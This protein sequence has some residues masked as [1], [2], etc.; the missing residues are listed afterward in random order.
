M[1]HELESDLDSLINQKHELVFEMYQEQ[2]PDFKKIENSL[3]EIWSLL[4]NPKEN[5][6]ESF[7]TANALFVLYLEDFREF[8][9]AEVWLDKLRLVEEKIHYS[10]GE[11]LFCEGRLYFELEEYDKAFKTFKTTVKEGK[12]LRYFEDEDPKYLDFYTH[13][14]KYQ[15]K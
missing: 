15:S 11:V 14:E 9:D 1:T 6:T 3:L 10:I 7:R 12:G 5:W 13:P 4:P 2:N 8:K